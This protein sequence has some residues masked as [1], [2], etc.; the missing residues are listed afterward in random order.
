MDARRALPHRIVN[1]RRPFSS[2]FFSSLS[3]ESLL[4]Q[5]SQFRLSLSSMNKYYV[6]AVFIHYNNKLTHCVLYHVEGNMS[7]CILLK[8]E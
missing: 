1:H 4:T 2:F 7:V 5:V 8:N 6:Y 3:F